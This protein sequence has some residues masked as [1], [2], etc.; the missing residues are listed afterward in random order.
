M[1]PAVPGRWWRWEAGRVRSGSAAGWG[2]GVLKA[3]L[4]EP[5][6]VVDQPVDLVR[7][8][9]AGPRGDAERDRGSGGG[10]R[11]RE[12]DRFRAERGDLGFGRN[13][14]T[15]DRLPD[16]ES[17]RRGL[18]RGD[19]FGAGAEVAG[20]GSTAGDHAA[21]EGE[22]EVAFGVELLDAAAVEDV[23][24]VVGGAGGVVVDGDLA[25]IVERSGA[26]AAQAF[27]A[28]GGGWSCLRAA[29]LQFR[30]A[31]GDS[32]AEGEGEVVFG[33]ALEDVDAPVAAVG[34]VEAAGFE[35][36]REALG[37]FALAGGAA[38]RAD[39]EVG[40]GGGGKSERE[41]R[42]RQRQE[43][44]RPPESG[45]GGPCRSSGVGASPG[46]GPL[47]SRSSFLL[48]PVVPRERCWRWR[49]FF[50]LPLRAFGHLASSSGL[51]LIVL[52]L[53]AVKSAVALWEPL[54]MLVLFCSRPF[55]P[56]WQLKV[57][58]V[59]GASG[60]ASKVVRMPPLTESTRADQVDV[61]SGR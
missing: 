31:V 60:T 2:S 25:Q 40:R 58:L 36:D 24:V 8:Y 30:G 13:A 39:L 26:A 59:T 5:E 37:V 48:E 44:Q 50:F 35:V 16:R 28:L 6:P 42:E 21:A 54:Q 10:G 12:R 9:V 15:G 46:I 43:R 14:R 27:E 4:G 38:V 19:L 53:W 32:P 55:L 57:N 34:D 56:R 45:P 3:K 61:G 20:P 49:C 7:R 41:G 18:H 17:L 1:P 51:S 52:P 47:A 29:A 11:F 33:A 22:Q 23:D